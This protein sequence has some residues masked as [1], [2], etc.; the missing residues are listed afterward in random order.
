MPLP[1]IQFIFQYF[2]AKQFVPNEEISIFEMQTLNID[3]LESQLPH[4]LSDLQQQ[5]LIASFLI[6]RITIEQLMLK[7]YTGDTSTYN[8]S[9]QLNFRIFSATLFVIVIN[10]FQ[11]ELRSDDQTSE[12]IRFNMINGYAN[13]VDQLRLKED[14]SQST[15]AQI[16]E[17]Y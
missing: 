6:M 7:P 1:V 13:I 8:E 15:R 16:E 4:D 12:D 3:P 9:V 14:S 2:S 10:Y 5:V 11:K 17:V